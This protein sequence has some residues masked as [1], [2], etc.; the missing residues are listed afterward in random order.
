MQMMYDIVARELKAMQLVDSLPQDYLN[1]Y[2]LGNRDDACDESSSDN[3]NMPTKVSVQNESLVLV[4]R[5]YMLLCSF[6][7]YV[8]HL[9][10]LRLPF[11]IHHPYK[12][13]FNPFS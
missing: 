12:I 1:F 8:V 13:N 5:D 10:F 7:C 4:H 11:F 6:A 9:T 3:A 2:C